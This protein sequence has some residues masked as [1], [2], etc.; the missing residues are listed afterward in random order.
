MKSILV[1]FLWLL[2]FPLDASLRINEVMQSNINTVLDDLNEY[3]DG[4]VELFNDGDEAL[5]LK[6]YALGKKSVFE[7][8]YT[9][10]DTIVPSGGYLL[11]YCDKEGAGLHTSFRLETD[12]KSALYLFSP[13]GEIADTVFLPEMMIPNAAYARSDEGLWGYA[14][15]PT[16]MLKNT[17]T[18]HGRVVPAPMFSEV[19]GIKLDSF[20]LKL[21]LPIGAPADARIYFTTN[22][23][24]PTATDGELYEKPISIGKSTVV[25]AKCF[26]DSAVSGVAATQ[27]YLFLNRPQT[28]PV[29]SIV[30][31]D[32]NFHDDEVGIYTKGTYGLTHPESKPVVD[33]FGRSNYYYKWDRPVNVEYF[34]ADGE[35]VINQICETRIGGKASRRK[36]VKALV[37]KADERFGKQHFNYPFFADK[38]EVKKNKS[39]VLRASGQDV[40]KTF[41]RDAFAQQSFAKPAGVDFQSCQPVI[42]FYNGNYWGVRNIRER[43]NEDFLWANYDKLKD[44]DIVEDLGGSVKYGDSTAFVAFRKAYSN[45]ETP[46][47]VLDSL[48]DVEEFLDYLAMYTLFCNTDF[49]ANNMMMWR[50][51]QPGSKWRWMAKD[52][53]VSMGFVD[54][55]YFLPYMNYILREEPFFNHGVFNSEKVC[56]L[57]QQVM[58]YPQ[59]RDRFVD[60]LSVYMGTFARP[61]AL[62]SVVDSM[63]DNIAFEMPFFAEIRGA[64]EQKW[65]QSLEQLKSWINKRVPFL[66]SDISKFFKLGADV[67]MQIAY[68]GN[69]FMNGIPLCGELFDGRYYQGRPFTLSADSLLA[70]NK[71]SSPLVWTASRVDECWREQDFSF[72]IGQ[73]DWLVQYVKGDSLYTE[74]FEGPALSWKIPLGATSVRISRQQGL[75]PTTVA[76]RSDLTFE[77]F[78]FSGRRLACG[79]YSEVMPLLR[80]DRTYIFTTSRLGKVVRRWKVRRFSRR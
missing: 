48:M 33:V 66:Y 16:P 57:F 34:T 44:V 2:T 26:S 46:F 35:Q 6:D 49:P 74:G 60:K 42:L 32:L 73:F 17:K 8:A 3:P 78:D 62:E 70:G 28:L 75:T 52:F 5:N 31:D 41:L 9:L 77:V 11:V 65:Q 76:D 67:P 13:D 64:D 69:L 30:T 24:T 61:S 40:D 63:A 54:S 15:R 56:R 27:S 45:S 10:P 12:K 80:C 68:S 55:P 14:L 7:K 38:P 72:P 25:R 19:G 21:S 71:D 20:S 47:E 59:C 79:S 29:V 22:G 51:R 53:D 37:L 50:P 23:A 43:G 58:S 39:I 4:W 36:R 18:V 1:V